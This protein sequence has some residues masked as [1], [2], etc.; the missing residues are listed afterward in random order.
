MRTKCKHTKK[1]KDVSPQS[2]GCEECKKT[3]DS[4]V[5]LRMCMTCGQV[6]C[7][8]ASENTHARKHFEKTG[9]PIV[10]SLESGE[11]W[12]W[13]YIDRIYIP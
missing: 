12:M 4:W 1:I 10:K 9:H 8:D 2:H 13:C 11:N 5:Y 6:G 3:G 7:C